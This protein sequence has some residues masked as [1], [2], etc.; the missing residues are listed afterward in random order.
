MQIGKEV[1]LFMESEF[2]AQQ[3]WLECTL[4]VS[5]Y[6]ISNFPNDVVNFFIR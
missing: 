4:T 5:K 2:Q 1:N 3:S 6:V